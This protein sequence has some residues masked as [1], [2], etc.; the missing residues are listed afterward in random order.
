[1]PLR[2][3][4]VHPV[5]SLPLLIGHAHLRV[6]GQ[7]M[8]PTSVGP[9]SDLERVGFMFGERATPNHLTFWR[10]YNRVVTPTLVDQPMEVIQKRG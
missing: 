4:V 2:D 9:V 8:I 3:R 6:K 1:M 10:R 5:P 7:S